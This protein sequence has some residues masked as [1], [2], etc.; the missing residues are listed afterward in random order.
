MG[1][2]ATLLHIEYTISFFGIG[3]EALKHFIYGQSDLYIE[4]SEWKFAVLS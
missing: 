2:G 1:F 4:F 3:K